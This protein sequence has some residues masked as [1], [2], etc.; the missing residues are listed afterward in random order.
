MSDKLVMALVG[1]GNSANR[2][3]LPY[4]LENENVEIKTIYTPS[5]NKRPADQDALVARGIQF[6]DDLD[7]VVND[8]EIQ[9]VSV[10]TPAPSHFELAK[11]L[12]EAG[13]NVMVEKPFVTSVAEGKALIE[14]ANEK[15]LLI[16][17]FQNRRFDGEFMEL[18]YVLDHG[19]IGEPIEFESHFDYFR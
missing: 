7:A 4:L 10:I 17:P 6:T 11:R 1:F 2:Y 13:K 12:L 15:G 9:F 14:L 16:T 18:Q 3:H 19:F 5:L 8:P